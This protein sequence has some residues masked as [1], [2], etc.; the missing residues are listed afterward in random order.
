[1]TFC[2]YFFRRIEG[3]IVTKTFSGPLSQLWF[4][5]HQYF[6]KISF[7]ALYSHQELGSWTYTW[8]LETAQIT[9]IYT[10]SNVCTVT[11]I[12]ACA[13]HEYTQFSAASQSVDTIIT[14]D[15]TGQGHH[16]GLR[17][18]HKPFTSIWTLAV[19]QPTVI[20]LA[21][22]YSTGHEYLHNLWW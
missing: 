4:Y 5:S 17:E 13:K 20:N 18:Q 11:W 21:S 8:F 22:F 14:L 16:Y 10:V 15:G 6:G 9:D 1:M 3:K 12:S 7:L 19:A 2:I